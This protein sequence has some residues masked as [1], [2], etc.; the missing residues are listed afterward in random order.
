MQADL[1]TCCR[2]CWWNMATPMLIPT[3]LSLAPM[4]LPSGRVMHVPL[5]IVGKTKGMTVTVSAASVTIDGQ[6]VDAKISE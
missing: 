4:Q 1:D 6:D 2:Q 5:Q 3:P